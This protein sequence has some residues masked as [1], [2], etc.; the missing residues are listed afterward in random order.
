MEMLVFLLEKAKFIGVILA[1]ILIGHLIL[2]KS[3]WQFYPLY[4]VVAAYF[5]LVLLHYFSGFTLTERNSRWILGIGI[6]LTVISIILILILPIEDLPKPSGEYKIG[7][8][9]FDLEDPS[10]EEVYTELEGDFRKIKYQIW[11][12][13]DK[14][15]G[16]RKARW[17]TDGKALSRQLAR[18]MYLPSFMLDHTVQIESNSFLDAP[19][20]H[21]NTSYPVVII[22]HGWSGFRELHTDFAEELASNGFIAVSIDHTYGSQAVK[23]NDGTIAYLNKNALPSGSDQG[24][25]QKASNLLA[26][27]YGEDVVAVINDL[28]RLNKND[29]DF[30]TKLDLDRLGLLGHSTG[31]G[32]DVYTSLK[33][34]R[35]K[36]LIGLDAWV[37]P[38]ESKALARGLTM[39]SLFLRSEQWSQGP[40]NF[41]LNTLFKNSSDV[42]L[43]QLGETN[44][45][46]FSMAYMYSPITK[47]IGFTGKMGGRKSSKIQKEFILA[48]FQRHLESKAQSPEKYL[49]DIA[50]KY[51]NVSIVDVN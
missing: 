5:A 39:P 1:V 4:F 32:G 22:S 13:T 33:D 2:G 46:D 26:T 24:K 40:N 17:I 43:V 16:L 6:T 50:N 38:I 29:E 28:E 25:F 3:R 35:I 49:E 19:I 30:S 15:K 18:S 8:R 9:T 37:G 42:T 21:T 34:S 23:F 20:S 47:Y 45:V 51:E 14:T 44:H 7:T 10:R 27:T 11:Y 48:F 12:P 31:G 36:A 41:A